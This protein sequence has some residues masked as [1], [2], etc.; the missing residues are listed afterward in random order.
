MRQALQLGEEQRFDEMAT[1]LAEVLQDEPDE[2]YILGWLAVAE[3]ELGNDGAAYEYFK[4]CIAAEPLDPQL[5]ALAGSGLAA[6]DDPDAEAT[7]RAAAL[8][9]PELAITRLQ[10]GAYLAREGMFG[11][12]LEQLEAAARIEP[13]DPVVHGELGIAH[14]LKGD[15]Q[16]A[17]ASMERAIALAEDD[18]WTRVLHGL[19]LSELDQYEEAAEQLVR[20][21]SERPQDA[22]AQVL[23]ALAAAAVGWDDAAQDALARAEFA[24][25]GA[26][27]ALLTETEERLAVGAEAAA[28]LLRDTV[29]P[30]VLHDRL[31]HPL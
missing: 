14:A 17:A 13:E 2:P 27:P 15:L 3:R 8:I 19:V 7:L 31:T 23:A 20:A 6:F 4:R 5:L 11:E 9:G 1:M 24:E 22:E 21:A 26:D 30:S 10:Y 29:G 16:T 12:A 25:E 28:A 18:S